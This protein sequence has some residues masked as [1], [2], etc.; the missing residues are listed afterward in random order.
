MAFI[1]KFLGKRVE[2]P[3]DRCFVLN[4]G[5]W[6]KAENEAVVFGFAEPALVLAGGI[7]DIDWLVSEGQKVTKGQ[8]IVFVI[9]SKILYL[10]AP[11]T[12]TVHFHIRVKEN[13]QFVI[14]DPY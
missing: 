12:G 1:E 5:L 3:E 7:N 2:I 13:P 4:Q 9:T 10:E 11:I 8:A 6:A 14:K